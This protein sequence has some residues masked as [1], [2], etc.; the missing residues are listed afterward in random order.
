MSVRDLIISN[1][2]S[3][4]GLTEDPP[5]SNK[6]KYNDWYYNEDS[7]YFRNPK[8]YAY[9]A[10]AISYWMHHS[11]L[12]LPKL[13]HDNGFSYVPTLVLRALSNKWFTDIP[14]KGDIV[15]FDFNR[16]GKYDHVGLFLRHVSGDS[17]ETVEA[18]TS[19]NDS[20]SQ[21]NGGGVYK[22]M[23]K[24]GWGVKF[25]SL[26]KLHKTVVK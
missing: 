19:P 14:K 20:G 18:N 10:T 4:V 6:I 3:D 12:A 5:G 22:R 15:V 8:P 23:R 13:D 7:D 25:V 26:D 16:D 24:Y 11:G 17:F 2:L 21:S 9:C 1:A